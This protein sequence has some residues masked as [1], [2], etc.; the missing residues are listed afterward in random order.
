VDAGKIAVVARV[1]VRVL[2]L[3]VAVSFGALCVEQAEAVGESGSPE[4][5]FDFDRQWHGLLDDAL[6]QR[7][8]ALVCEEVDAAFVGIARDHADT[9]GYGVA[10]GVGVHAGV[11]PTPLDCDDNEVGDVFHVVADALLGEPVVGGVADQEV[12]CS[13]LGHLVDDV[14]LDTELVIRPLHFDLALRQ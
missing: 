1:V 14:V 8:V 6:R 11:G 13:A 2:I 9:R 3:L 4:V 7:N 5:L 10:D 12:A